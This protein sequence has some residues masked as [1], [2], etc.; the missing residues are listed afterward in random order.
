MPKSPYPELITVWENIVVLLGDNSTVSIQHLT[1]T[2]PWKKSVHIQF[3]GQCRNCNVRYYILYNLEYKTNKR[4]K[5]L[6][7]RII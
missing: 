3:N 5:N 4:F 6:Y 1:T 7:L 2:K